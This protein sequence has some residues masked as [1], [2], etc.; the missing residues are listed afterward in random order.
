MG[1]MLL[2]LVA[3]GVRMGFGWPWFLGVAIAGVLFARQLR[4]VRGGDRTA[5]FEAFLDNNRVG[6]VLFLGLLLHYV[7]AGAYTAI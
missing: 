7:F 5:C 3:T 6:L 4:R 1:L 2:M